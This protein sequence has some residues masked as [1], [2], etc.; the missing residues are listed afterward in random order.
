MSFV[1]SGRR[2]G[3]ASKWVKGGFSPAIRKIF[4]GTHFLS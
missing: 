2:I 4:S 1:V 3:A